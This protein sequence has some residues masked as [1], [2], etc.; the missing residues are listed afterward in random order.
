[1]P[2]VTLHIPLPN[3]KNKTVACSSSKTVSQQATHHQPIKQL[4]A[5]AVAVVVAVAVA[6]AVAVV[7]VDIRINFPKV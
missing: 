1:L 6:V 3:A 5:V 7:V 2:V 4:A